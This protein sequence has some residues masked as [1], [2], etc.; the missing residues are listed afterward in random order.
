[1]RRMIFTVLILSREIARFVRTGKRAGKFE[2]N[3]INGFCLGL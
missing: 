2:L 1:M 3:N